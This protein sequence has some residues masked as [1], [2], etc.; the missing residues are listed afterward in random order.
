MSKPVYLSLSIL[1]IGKTLMYH[2]WY[3]FIKPKY[4]CI[5]K[6]CYMDIASFT[7]HSKTEDVYR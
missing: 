4:K 2:F 1:K 5:A 6:L 7:I 3:D